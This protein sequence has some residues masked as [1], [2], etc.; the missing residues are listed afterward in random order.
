[1]SASC[2]LVRH[3]RL[4]ISRDQ[5]VGHDPQLPWYENRENPTRQ[6]A[7]ADAKEAGPGLH[8]ELEMW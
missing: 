3:H 6:D 7:R 2:H 8:R 4:T 1:M 5:S